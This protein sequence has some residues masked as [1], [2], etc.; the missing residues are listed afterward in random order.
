MDHHCPWVANC[1]GFYN[2]K[3]FMCML[4]YTV[5]ACHMIIWT[6]WPLLVEV[7]SSDTIDYKIAYYVI[8]SYIL[9]CTLGLIITGFLGFH[10]Y[11]IR[12]QWTT[13]EYCEKRAGDNSSGKDST[14]NLG[15]FKNFQIILGNNVLLWFFP[16]FPNTEGNGLIF[17]VRPSFG[18]IR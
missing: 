12:K 9:A 13:I 17:E 7:L 1:I 3:Y 10:L 11:L 2:Y 15:T 18:L 14:Y 8:T 6:S 5:A 4:F 16:I